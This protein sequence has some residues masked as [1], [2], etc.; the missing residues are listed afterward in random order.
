MTQIMFAWYSYRRPLFERSKGKKLVM[1]FFEQP[2]ER[3][4]SRTGTKNYKQESGSEIE[5]SKDE[6]NVHDGL[7]NRR[8][9]NF[10]KLVNEISQVLH[11]GG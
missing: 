8:L 6:V 9:P 7:D 11:V 4:S 1:F 10:T 5:D 3:V 2:N